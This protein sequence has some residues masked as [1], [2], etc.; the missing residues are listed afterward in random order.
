LTGR[1]PAAKDVCDLLRSGTPGAGTLEADACQKTCDELKSRGVEFVSPP[2][3]RFYGI[4]ALFK[5]NSGN[6]FS[7]TQHTQPA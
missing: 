1:L 3:E 5:D 6:W 7:M 4:E 2:T